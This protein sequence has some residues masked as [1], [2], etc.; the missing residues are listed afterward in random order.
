MGITD[1]SDESMK[2]TSKLLLTVSRPEFVPANSASFFIGISWGINLPV[3][4]ISGVVIPSVLTFSIITLIAAFGAQINTIS[5][6]ELDSKDSRKKELVQA[7]GKLGQDKLKPVMVLELI[8]SFVLLIILFLN[9]GKP[10]LPIMWIAMVFLA[11]TYSAPP[12][13]LKS[14]SWLAVISLL[15]VL[16]ILPILF[17]YHTFTS[18]LNPFFL[19]FLSGQALVVYGVIIPAEIRDY[20]GDKAL[21]IETMTVKLG[22]GKASLFALLLLTLGGILCGTG[23]FLKL[24]YGAYPVLTVLLLFMAVTFYLILRKYKT[25]Y[26]LSKKYRSSKERNTIEQDIVKLSAQNPKWITL[27]TQIIL[28]MSI[29]VLVSKIIS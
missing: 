12:L 24:V 26:F 7:M 5:D 8:L 21:G 2:H 20:W 10:A 14:R 18:E 23:L 6:Y 4:L 16:S 1:Y 11:Y 15:I 9:Q 13:R 28:I 19:L 25:L 17:I 27:I 22:L 3:D 29:V